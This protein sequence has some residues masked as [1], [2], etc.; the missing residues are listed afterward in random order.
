MSV[1]DIVNVQVSSQTAIVSQAGFGNQLVLVYHTKDSNRVLEFSSA[2]SML[3]ANGGPFDSND[4]AYVLAS[5]AFAQNPSSPKVIIG[6]RI[7]PTIRNVLMTP[8]SGVIAGETYPLNTTL[9]RVTINGVNFDYT[10]DA[11]ATAAEISLNLTTLINAGSENVLATD[12][13]GSFTVQAADAP[14]GSATAGIPFTIEYDRTLMTSKDQTPVAVGGSLTDEIAAIKDINNDWY[15]ITGDW[16]GEAEATVVANAI[17]TDGKLHAFACA[18]DDILD[19]AI[20]SDVVSNLQA[21]NLFK[22][23]AAHHTKPHAGYAV[24]RLGEA[25]PTTPGSI[26]WAN[27][28]LAGIE[29]IKYTDSEITALKNK[30]ADSYQMRSE[31]LSLT[32]TG[33]VV[34]GEWIDVVRTAAWARKILLDAADKV[35]KENNR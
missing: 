32:Q 6:R 20:S 18:D 5:K 13:V 15:G 17:E 19:Q 12:L 1:N 29:S 22:T 33:K 23:I 3:T 27:R 28:Q 4:L 21:L 26:T 8:R 7:F 35:T 16:F 24:G 34:G 10:T 25:L 30:N 14:G 31:S 9:Y 2:D 11:T